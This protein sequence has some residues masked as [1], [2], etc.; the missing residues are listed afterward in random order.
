[1]YQSG[2]RLARLQEFEDDTMGLILRDLRVNRVVPISQFIM[3]FVVP[4][5]RSD[6][7]S[8]T[9]SP[10]SYHVIFTRMV[11]EP[12]ISGSTFQLDYLWNN[13]A[14]GRMVTHQTR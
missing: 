14:H 4:L 5:S 13:H 9:A 1:M 3:S 8:R 2:L 11:G 6:R 12:V 10:E 7:Y